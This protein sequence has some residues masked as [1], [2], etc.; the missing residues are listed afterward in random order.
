MLFYFFE[1]LSRVSTLYQ[2]VA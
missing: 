2:R 1:Q